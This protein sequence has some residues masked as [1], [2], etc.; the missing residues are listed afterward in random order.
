[1]TQLVELF[2]AVDGTADGPADDG[3]GGVA[4]NPRGSRR[5]NEE[6]IPVLTLAWNNSIVV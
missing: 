6:G 3:V 1:M 2:Q 5:L 4:E